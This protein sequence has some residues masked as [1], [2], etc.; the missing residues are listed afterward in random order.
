MSTA[1]ILVRGEKRR[2]YSAHPMEGSGGA[3]P[4]EQVVD[5]ADP[6]HGGRGGAHR[7]DAGVR[8]V[9]VLIGPQ[10]VRVLGDQ[11]LDEGDPGAEVTAVG[12]PLVHHDHLGAQGLHGRHVLRR[13]RFGSVTQVNR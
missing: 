9:P 1:M 7:M 2:K 5:R 6:G 10:Q 12:I 8:R 13:P 11:T 4:D 3:R